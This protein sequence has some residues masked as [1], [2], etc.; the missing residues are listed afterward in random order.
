MLYLHPP[1][2]SY[3]GVSVVGDY[4]DPRQFYYY[5]NRPQLAVD[6]QGRPAIRFIAFRENLDELEADEDTAAGFL[7]FDTSL[8]WPEETLEK[9]AQKIQDDL[10][11][12]QLPRLAP[13]PYRDGTVRV[14]FLDRTTEPPTEGETTETPLLAETTEGTEEQWVPFLETSGVPSLYGENRAIFS[15]ML[16]KK[17][18][19]LMYGAFEGF[20]PAGVV[21][22]LSYVG[23]QRAFNVHVEANWEQVYH[24]IRESFS[25]DFVFVSVNKTKIIDELEEKQIIKIEAS[26]EGIGDE[27]MEDEFN[28]VRKELEDFVLEKFFKPVANPKQLETQGSG[29]G[30]QNARRIVNLI[31]NWPTVGYSRLELN[32]SEIRTLD[33]D[34]TVTRAV[35]RRIAPQAHLSLFFEDYNLT[36]EQ[37]VTVVDGRD[38]LWEEVNFEISANTD[39]ESDGI[40]GISVDIYYGLP[41][42][43]ETDETEA[44]QEFPATWSFLLD[45]QQPNTQ[46]AAWYNP[47]V[48]HQFRY[49]YT[50]H[51]APD[52][53]PGPEPTLTSGW[54]QHDSHVLVINPS[55]LYQKR[56]V[57][58]QLVRG[59][60]SDFYPQVHVHLRYEDEETGWAY[61]DSEL[62]DAEKTRLPLTFRSRRGADAAVDYRF[63][64]LRSDGETVDT[65]WQRTASDLVLVKDPLP[66]NL[67][68]RVVVAGDRSQI[69]NLIVDFKYEDLEN[70]VFESGSILIDPSNISQPQ[71]WSI[72]LKDPEQRRYWYSQTL[73]DLDGNVMQTGWI[74][75]EKTTLLVGPI[76]VKQME[77]QPELIGPPLSAN[78]IERIKL[79]LHYEDA[80]NDHRSEQQM[81]FSAPGKGQSWRLQLQDANRRDYSYEVIYIM[82]T[83]FESKVGPLASQDTFL[84]ISTI[85]PEA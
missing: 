25:A 55:E 15:A 4:H 48:G 68:V 59:F 19:A 60:P 85:P 7:V 16:S 34:Y 32:A 13:L 17:A 78:G 44:P 18:T 69:A 81:I 8:A 2:Y 76:Y 71:Q 10:D 41:L 77:V 80:L 64:Y 35:E 26:I 53:I 37:V 21:Y 38:A 11:L 33:I 5:P 84:V 50:V 56:A 22:D 27:G 47:E 57:E 75:E 1:F 12:D 6:E 51:F 24:H 73:I 72:P 82:N 49:R 23:M 62:L 31:N 40:R 61:E 29:E 74:Q 83:G 3:E 45:S 43:T 66:E 20:M 14:T 28:A 36:R 79:N 54:Q 70:Q 30:I 65:S 42:S 67:E 39:F 46:K 58:A 52:A 63:S 9:V